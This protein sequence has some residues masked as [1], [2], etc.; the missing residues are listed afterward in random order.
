MS[1]FDIDEIQKG[2]II[3]VSYGKDRYLGYVH[4]I[5]TAEK[6]TQ[7]TLLPMAP[8][9]ETLQGLKADSVEITDASVLTTSGLKTP[10]KIYMFGV[11]VKNNDFMGGKVTRIGYFGGQTGETKT[12]IDSAAMTART[13]NSKLFRTPFPVLKKISFPT[14]NLG[15]TRVSSAFGDK[16]PPTP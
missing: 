10:H 4:N 1:L 15:T 8:S 11:T 7:F 6:I 13:Q 3:V 5:K 9:T 2:N 16:P 12:A 14:T